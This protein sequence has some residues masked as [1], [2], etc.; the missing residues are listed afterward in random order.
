MD[1]EA[2]IGLE[3]HAQL[4]TRTK[5][6]CACRTDFGAPPNTL[7]CPVCLGLPGVLPVV[8]ARAVELAL[9]LGLAVSA[10]IE[11]RSVFARKNYF[12]P[13]MPKNYQISQYELPL[14]RG[15]HLD[16]RIGDQTRRVG[17]E[18]IHLE[19]DAG[20]SLHAAGPRAATRLDYNRA[21]VPL[22][23]IVSLP[24]LR[25]GE[26]ARAWLTRLRQLLL[27]LDI[28]DG[29]LEEGS[30]R[31]DANVSV[32]P[33]GATE[34][35]AKTEIKN[36]NSF[37]GV[38]RALDH[39]IARHAATLARGEALEQATYTWDAAAGR[40]VFMRS[41]EFAHDYRYF[42]EPDL[43]PLVVTEAELAAV[44]AALP[45]LPAARE[46]RLRRQY[47]LPAYDAAV[48]TD[49]PALADYF[50][51]TARVLGD[52]KQASNWIMG[53]VLKVVNERGLDVADFPVSPAE[54]AGLLAL[55][56]DG[57]I[58]G[59]IAKE[60]FAE[61]LATGAAAAAIVAARG[62]RQDSDAPALAALVETVLAAHPQEVAAYH[63]G[64]TGILGFFVGQVLKATGG[65]AN[66]A[67]VNDLVQ[68]GLAR[69]R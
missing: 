20:K 66:P 61:M 39:E 17:L 27:H 11:R 13:D 1:F 42:P 23:E 35:G 68:S 43:P 40:T 53:E 8:N 3:V 46:E 26:E 56:R 44:A 60:V 33:R 21:G 5:M 51:A 47:A 10:R 29:N 7:T 31:C 67:L 50:E 19:E 9:R 36:L 28:C 48:L 4:K 69:R 41:K 38:E 32:R 14:C 22:L 64:R 57:A 34:L 15:G 24:E 6:F 62:L 25:G 63:G 49:T 30:L 65:Q 37:R 2:V 54:L 58:S 12:Y 55:V 59:K 18:R 52:G 16:V 45:E